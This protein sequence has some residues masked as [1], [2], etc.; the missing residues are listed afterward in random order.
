LGGREQGSLK[1]TDYFFRGTLA[2]TLGIHVL[3]FVPGLHLRVE[4]VW[5]FALLPLVALI[6]IVASLFRMPRR[7]YR[8]RLRRLPLWTRWGVPIAGLYSIAMG[9][10]QM[11]ASGRPKSLATGFVLMQHGRIVRSLTETEYWQLARAE[12]AFIFG[13]LLYFACDALL[14]RAVENQPAS[15]ASRVEPSEST[16]A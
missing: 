7:E 12:V 2:V 14:D 1:P 10:N 15:S 5:P 4:F 8:A 6:T 11:T 13:W 9:M 16:H 3:G